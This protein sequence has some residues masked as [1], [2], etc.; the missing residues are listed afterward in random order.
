[1]LISV[2]KYMYT[3]KHSV[4]SAVTSNLEQCVRNKATSMSIEIALYYHVY[5]HIIH[6]YALRILGRWLEMIC[7]KPILYRYTIQI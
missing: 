2:C 1:M 4:N 7:Q 5:I 3:Y 6:M